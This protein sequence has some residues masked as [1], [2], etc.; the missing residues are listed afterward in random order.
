MHSLSV[1]TLLDAVRPALASSERARYTLDVGTSIGGFEIVGLL[2][3]GASAEVYRV[4]DPNLQQQYALKL[5]VRQEDAIRTA[6]RQEIHLLAQLKHPN[7]LSIMHASIW[8]ERDFSITPLLKPLPDQPSETTVY[9]WTLILCDVL[10]VLNA[11][12]VVHRDIKLNNVL[13]DPQKQEP[14]LADFGVA[15]IR[16]KSQGLIAAS[17]E[18]SAPEQLE[19]IATPTS[20]VYALARLLQQLLPESCYTRSPWRNPL[21][22]ALAVSPEMRYASAKDFAHALRRADLVYHWRKLLLKIAIVLIALLTPITIIY[23]SYA[24]YQKRIIERAQATLHQEML[25]RQARTIPTVACTDS[26]T[27]DL[28]DHPYDIAYCPAID[29]DFNKAPGKLR[30]MLIHIPQGKQLII[31]T[32]RL[33]S[34]TIRYGHRYQLS[35][36]I[37][38][39]GA[40]TINQFIPLQNQRLPEL[41][42]MTYKDEYGLYRSHSPVFAYEIRTAQTIT[43]HLP[44]AKPS[45]KG[46]YSQRLFLKKIEAKWMPTLSYQLQW[47]VRSAA[48]KAFLKAHYPP[49]RDEA[50]KIMREEIKARQKQ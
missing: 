43:T 34:D 39:E 10:E 33:T 3:V 48:G 49:P 30:L 1:E 19:G 18:S 40:C 45:V 2:G 35:I 47:S 8:H 5:L 41:P 46:G 20:D 24:T 36:I 6:F 29:I 38:G 11:N 23:A 16:G 42:E 26:A 25:E 7:I 22:K 12:G 32:L 50:Q 27:L 14:I 37:T 21:T 4:F 28:T 31:E 13:Y 15:T 9:Q 17:P 44:E